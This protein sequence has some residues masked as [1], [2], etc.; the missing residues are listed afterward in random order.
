MVHQK[1]R[2]EYL[3]WSHPHLAITDISYSISAAKCLTLTIRLVQHC[4]CFART[5]FCYR[6]L[7]YKSM[8][9]LKESLQ[10]LI[11]PLIIF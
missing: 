3:L 6:M 7:T 4:N 8:V 2:R 9:L 10:T 5:F 11:S 1:D